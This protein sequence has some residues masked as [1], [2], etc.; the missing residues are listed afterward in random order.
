MAVRASPARGGQGGGSVHDVVFAVFPDGRA[1]HR[2]ACLVREPLSPPGPRPRAG[3]RWRARCCAAGRR[4]SSARPRRAPTGAHRRHGA[5]EGQEQQPADP[6]CEPN[7]ATARASPVTR[8]APVLRCSRGACRDL[9]RVEVSTRAGQL[10]PVAASRAVLS[11]A[12]EN[13]AQHSCATKQKSCSTS[14]DALAPRKAFACVL[15]TS[16]LTPSSTSRT[17]RFRPL[18]RERNSPSR[19]SAFC[20]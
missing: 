2:F 18:V 5:R 14:R 19:S 1:G 7:T 13:P 12:G 4:W 17:S 10:H 11:R 20:R 16:E 3:G 15:P 8:R 6:C 9:P